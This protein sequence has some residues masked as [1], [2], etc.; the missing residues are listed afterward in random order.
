MK[1]TTWE[2]IIP[3]QIVNFIYKSQDQKAGTR[4]W[5]ICIDPKYR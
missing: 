3:G 5:T 1:N 4:R 2:R